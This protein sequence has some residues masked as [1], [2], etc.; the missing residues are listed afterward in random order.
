[1]KLKQIIILLCLV[2]VAHAGKV[3]WNAEGKPSIELSGSD[4]KGCSNGGLKE[5]IKENNTT[6][7]KCSS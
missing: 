3:T 1:M 5:L 4:L 7:E 6:K 2:V